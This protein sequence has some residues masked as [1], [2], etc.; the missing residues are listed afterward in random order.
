MD[1][2][3]AAPLAF[4]YDRRFSPTRAILDLRLEVCRE[5]AA[6]M[7]WDIAGP[8]VDEDDNAM[9][10][11]NRPE[12]AEMVEAMRKATAMGRSALC[13]INDWDRLSRDPQGNAVFRRQIAQAGGYTVTSLGEDDRPE[14]GRGRLRALR[15]AL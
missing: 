7:R 9:S 4:I 12:F 11:T 10:D 3:P 15:P 1:T 8:Y 5:Y 6:E 13:L 2:S 14:T